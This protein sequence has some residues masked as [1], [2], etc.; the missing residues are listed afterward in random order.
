MHRRRFAEI[1]HVLAAHN[2]RLGLAFQAAAAHREGRGIPFLHQGETLLTLIKT[3]G[4]RHVGL[5]L[6]TW[7]WYAGGAGMDQLREFPPQQIMAAL[8]RLRDTKRPSPTYGTGPDATWRRWRRRRRG[9]FAMAGRKRLRR[10]RHT[11]SSSIVFP[12]HDTRRDHAAGQRPVRCAVSSRPDQ[13]FRQSR[14]VVERTRSRIIA[15]LVPYV[16]VIP[17]NG[18]MPAVTLLSIVPFG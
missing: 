10:P 13:S 17:V 14:T 18:P 3:V 1:G 15:T 6:D 11:L 12:R 9:D 8:R 4:S 7:D 2:I 16:T 5:T